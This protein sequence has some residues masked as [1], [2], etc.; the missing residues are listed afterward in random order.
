V[1]AA[2]VVP[3]LGQPTLPLSPL[4]LRPRPPPPC[5]RSIN[6]HQHSAWTLW[7]V[8]VWGYHRTLIAQ[9][10]LIDQF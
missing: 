10:V 9:N 3:G 8:L 2:L 5:L 6:Q 1:E 4:S 7:I